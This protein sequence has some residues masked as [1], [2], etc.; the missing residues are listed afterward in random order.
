MRIIVT[1]GAGF[2]GSHL[3][4]LLIYSGHRVICLDNLLTA[5]LA[6]VRHLSG[7][8]KFEFLDG[9]VADGLCIDG[10]VDY[11]LHLA[12]PSSPVDFKTLS[13]Q[14]LRAN[15]LGTLNTLELALR[16]KAGFLLAS[17][18]EVYGDPL[19]NPQTE[20]YWGNVN[21]IGIRAV[22]DESK[23]FAEA[24]TMSYH[25]EKGLDTKIARI[26]NTY[27]PRM[28]KDDGRVVITFISQALTG[29][30][31]TI[32]GDGSQTR[33]FCYVSDLVEGIYRLMLSD[34]HVPVNLGNPDQITVHDLAT[35]VLR[36]ARSNSIVVNR[37]LPEND[38]RLR[39]PDISR[40]EQMLGWHSKVPLETGL[41][42]TIDWFRRTEAVRQGG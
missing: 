33:S 16:K 9:D 12:S 3:C 27:G 10:E 6:N 29:Q 37:P 20:D 11:V 23:R 22:Y 5:S 31:L 36:I 13:L 32:F 18:S 26:F 21:P 35:R 8:G 39:R 30:P 19:V 34:V 4:D 7:S 15:A 14:I 2:I 41:Q 28:R 40:A 38:P 42:K 17:T 1:G 25:R 24:A